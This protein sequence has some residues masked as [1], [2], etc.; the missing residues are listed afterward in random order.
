M[1][2]A[3]KDGNSSEAMKDDKHGMKNDRVNYEPN[4]H[5]EQDE[6][7]TYERKERMLLGS[8]PVRHHHDNA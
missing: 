2:H 7:I 8:C 3:I 5:M 4:E 6:N 1:N